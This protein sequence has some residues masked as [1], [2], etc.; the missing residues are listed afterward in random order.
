M[1]SSALNWDQGPKMV[2]IKSQFC[3]NVANYCIKGVQQPFFVVMC[4]FVDTVHYETWHKNILRVHNS[5]DLI[6]FVVEQIGGRLA[7][8]EELRW[9]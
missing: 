3:L 9:R 7:Q 1:L 6:I 5:F 4:K 8:Q 2:P